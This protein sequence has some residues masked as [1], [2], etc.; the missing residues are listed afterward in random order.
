MKYFLATILTSILSLCVNAVPSD[1]AVRQIIQPDGLTL[2]IRIVG[3]ENFHYAVSADGLCIVESENGGWYY[4]GMDENSLVPTMVLAHNPGERTQAEIKC[5][6]DRMQRNFDEELHAKLATVW[7]EKMNAKNAMRRVAQQKAVGSRRT[8]SGEKKGLVILVEFANLNMNSPAANMDYTHMFN[9]HG[10]SKNNHVGSVSD[11]FYDQSYGQFSLTFDVVGPLKLT[12]NYGYYGANS[13]SGNHDLRA[14]EMIREA[15]ILADEYVNYKDYDW[16]DDGEVDQ[17]FVI[18]A[19]LGEASGGPSNTVWPHESHLRYYE[20]GKLSLDGVNIDQYA[21]SNELNSEKQYMGIGVAC[22]EF[23]HCLG[24]P[25]FY[26]VNYSGA[27]GMSYWSLMCAGSY[28]GPSGVGEVPCGFSAFERWYAGWLEYT[29]IKTLQH[30]DGM[31]SLEKTPVAYRIVNDACPNEYYLL[32]NHQ[33]GK[34]YNYVSRY[35]D[36]HGLLITHIDFDQ[37]AWTNNKVNS[38]AR[39]QRFSPICADNN[40]EETREGLAGDVFPGIKGIAQ[41]TNVSHVD[42]GGKLFNMNS[43]GGY[44]MNKSLYNIMEADGCIS[45]DVIFDNEL[46]LPATMNPVDV[47]SESFTARWT[48]VPS[49]DSYDIELTAVRSSMPPVIKKS[50]T[51]VV[52]TNKHTFTN[53][54]GRNFYYR[55]RANKN[56]ASTGWSEIMN[57]VLLEHDGIDDIRHDVVD[58]V[59]YDI[60]GKKTVSSGKHGVRIDRHGKKS[61]TH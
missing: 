18:Y 44:E 55:V 30:I 15:C 49:A 6:Q 53:L 37:Q 60:S 1:M 34:W 39:H 35:T 2:N 58:N 26:D 27:Y 51:N 46:S 50:I 41:L 7:R 54:E 56:G 61:V 32:E 9:E 45:L 25:D 11:Y 24:L 52:G 14:Y 5:V 28:N 8:Y 48:E 33:P 17:V 23:S 16:D 42:Y 59:M 19:G 21:C 38:S 40:Y 36:I 13:L 20:G 12:N 22:H 3:D 57:V 10:Y 31:E 29:D 47:T 4:A 43:H